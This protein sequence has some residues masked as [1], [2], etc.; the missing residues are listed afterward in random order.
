[1]LIQYVIVSIHILWHSMQAFMQ[2]C[3]S[4]VMV[5]VIIIIISKYLLDYFDVMEVVFYQTTL[6]Q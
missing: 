6:T 3:I 2:D 1:L 5:S 4:E